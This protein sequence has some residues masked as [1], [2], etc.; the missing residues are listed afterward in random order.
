MSQEDTEYYLKFKST[1][2]CTCYGFLKKAICSHIV[3]FSHLYG[4]GWFDLKI[5]KAITNA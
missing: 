5:S 3:A 4:M 1:P 2:S